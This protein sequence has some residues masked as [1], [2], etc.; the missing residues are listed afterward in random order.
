MC[1]PFLPLLYK[2]CGRAYGS[3]GGQELDEGRR[4]GRRETERQRDRER[5]RQRQGDRDEHTETETKRQRDRKFARCTYVCRQHTSAY[6]SIRQHTPSAYVSIRHHTSAYVNID[7]LW[8]KQQGE[9]VV[10]LPRGC[11]GPPETHGTC[12]VKTFT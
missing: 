7:I 5:Q 2:A 12:Q 10:G 3:R 1:S 4:E 6:V 9:L 8:V 11:S